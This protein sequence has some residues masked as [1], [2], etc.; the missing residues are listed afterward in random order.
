MPP[1]PDPPQ[2]GAVLAAAVDGLGGEHRPGQQQMAAAV[3][4]AMTEGPHLLVQA[5]TGTGKSL[6][7]LV[8]ALVH[9]LAT[10]HPVVVATATIALQRQVV[11]RDLPRLVE[12]VSGLLPRTPRVTLLK[13][14]RHYLCRHR[15]A[16]GIVEDPADALFAGPDGDTLG[17]SA[18]AGVSNL[19]REVARVRQWA[20]R[21]ATGDR[22][23]LVP[24]VSDR[25]WSQVSVSSR[26]CLG[27]RCPM[28][29]ECFAEHAR[30][31]A[32]AA[33][34]VVTNHALLAV[35]ALESIPLLPDHDV[36]VVDE[37]HELVDRVT[38]AATK[39]LTV[40]QAVRAAARARRYVPDDSAKALE[41]AAEMLEQALVDTP[42]GR[43][44]PLADPLRAALGM[45]R[46]SARAVL[47]AMGSARDPDGTR[48]IA[49]AGLDE[50]VQTAGE[51]AVGGAEVVLWLADEPRRGSVLRAAPLSVSGLL[52]SALFDQR[53]VVLTS[54]TLTI[55]GTF[56]PLAAQLGLVQPGS[57]QPG[58]VQPGSTRSPAP[59]ARWTGLDVGSPFDYPHQGILYVARHL[60][61]PGRDGLSPAVLDELVELVQAAGGRT[62]GLFS[63]RRAALVAAEVLRERLDVPVLCQGDDQTATLVAEFAEEPHTCLLGTLSLWQGVDVPGPSCQLVVVDRIPFPRPDDPLASARASAAS[64]AGRNGFLEV[65][66]ATAA[67]R[68]A[69]GVGRLIRSTSDRGVVAVLDPRLATARYAGYLRDSLPPFW[70]TTDPAQARR[71]LRALDIDAVSPIRPGAAR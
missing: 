35:D 1:D 66:A 20:P 46:D 26:E 23:E 22:D 31:R 13:G 29:E 12:S 3:A 16:G 42:P 2:V 8:P 61:Q 49:R 67:L 64:A 41:Q 7:Y 51:M 57:V 21:T 9:A 48:A 70:Y 36:V 37:G 34:V 45:V 38:G 52:R 50:V 63:S 18:G 43:I 5:G 55:G 60:P 39:E 44:E 68:L 33:D 25:A 27:T 53:T 10:G 54:A 11:E 17:T 69:Q 47:S 58:S 56:E 24:G 59:G 62:L 6:A 15:L 65:S 14:R 71:S 4:A 30:H 40:P 28:V 32:R 19:G